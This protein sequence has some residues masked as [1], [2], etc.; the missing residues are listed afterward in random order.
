M[1]SAKTD[2]PFRRPTSK[3]KNLKRLLALLVV[4]GVVGGIWYL[5]SRPKNVVAM[6]VTRGLAME[7]AYATCSVEA[8]DRVTVKSKLAGS[9]AELLVKEGQSVKKDELLA[10]LDAPSLKFQLS[11]GKT[12][13][14]AATRQASS[15]SPQFAALEAQAQGT[16]AQLDTA[17]SDRDR[18]RT[19]VASNAAPTAELERAENQVKVLEA[20]LNSQQA[21]LRSLKIDLRSRARV[22][23]TLT[24]E[25]AARLEDAEVR[26]PLA[27]VVLTR[28]VEVGE[29]VPV[30]GPL[31]KI[32][33][34]SDLILECS[35]DEADVGRIA[36]GK[37]TAVSLYAFPNQALRGSV[38][39]I[40]PDADR[41]K[42]SFLVKVKVNDAPAR[43]R[44]GM[45]AEVNIIIAQ[46]EQVLLAPSDA[47]NTSGS[48]W[49]IRDGRAFQTKIEIGVR[50]MLQTEIRKGL[51]DGDSV[52][53]KGGDLLTEKARVSVTYK[54]PDLPAKQTAVPPLGAA[55][56]RGGA[57]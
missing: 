21:Q 37:P 51:N 36:V 28:S 42:K 29:V 32:G 17:R 18:L 39:E 1:S 41:A 3:K 31:F 9:I 47:I 6:K 25:L 44:S 33:N 22:A 11:R 26:S 16:Q 48:V 56:N 10:R 2:A 43:M 40:A 45:T 50:D 53:I 27:G 20:Q 13:Q 30:N 54:Q 15:H 14:S 4:A 24:S 34:I 52:V 49:V 5:R 38:I 46:H 23:S 7:A 35:V 55:S 12:E 8:R 57:L 19:L